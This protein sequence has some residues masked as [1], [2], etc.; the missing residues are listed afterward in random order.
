MLLTRVQVSSAS[1]KRVSRICERL[2]FLP[3][4]SFFTFKWGSD[5]AV[6]I[7]N[8]FFMFVELL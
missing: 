7:D 5:S 4:L 2:L 8:E 1:V 6:K 3:V